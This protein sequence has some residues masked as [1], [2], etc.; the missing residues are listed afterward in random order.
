MQVASV[1]RHLL[2]IPAEHVV[3]RSRRMVSGQWI[4][5]TEPGKFVAK[6]AHQCHRPKDERQPLLPAWPST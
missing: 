4:G 3:K 1:Q 5:S 6:L 2:H